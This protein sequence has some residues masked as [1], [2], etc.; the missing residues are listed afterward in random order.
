MRY[1]PF[2][3]IIQVGISGNTKK[4]VEDISSNIYKY[5]QDT[6]IKHSVEM[7]V[8]KP[9]PAPIDKIKNKIRWRI[10]IKCKLDN[11]IVNILNQ[12]SQKANHYISKN[13]YS[14]RVIIDINPNNML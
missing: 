5:I 7:Q 2:C 6:A 14:S 11:R 10:I 1:P 4:E 13:K 12:T 8:F 3:D 9:V